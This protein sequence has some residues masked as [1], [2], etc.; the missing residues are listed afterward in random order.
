MAVNPLMSSGPSSFDAFG[1]GV[2]GIRAG[3][4]GMAHA[5]QEI[6]ELNVREAPGAEAPGAAPPDW[7]EGAADAL[8]DLRIYQRNVQAAA[9]VV[10]TADSVLGFLLDIHA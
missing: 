9:V 5:A 3:L 2:N 4:R 10:E 7:L 6:A 8:T 1:A